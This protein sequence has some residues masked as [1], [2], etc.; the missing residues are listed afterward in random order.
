MKSLSLIFSGIFL[1]MNVVT[2]APENPISYQSARV[3]G[4]DIFYRE[5]GPDAPTVLLLHGLPSSSRMFQPLKAN[6]SHFLEEV[7]VD[8]R[9]S[10]L[11]GAAQLFERPRIQ[12]FFSS[13]NAMHQPATFAKE[14]HDQAAKADYAIRSVRANAQHLFGTI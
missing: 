3:D 8:C 9:N 2:A 6:Y 7:V 10:G 14:G 11:W 13:A 12:N 1:T 5:A 4:L